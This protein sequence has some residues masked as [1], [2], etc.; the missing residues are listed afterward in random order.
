MTKYFSNHWLQ[1]DKDIKAA[2]I[3]IF[4]FPIEQIHYKRVHV[5]LIVTNH[6]RRLNSVDL[7][8]IF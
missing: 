1:F 7:L 5:S 8:G 4:I 6:R 3:N 2:L